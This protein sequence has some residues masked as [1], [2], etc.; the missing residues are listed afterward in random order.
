M[1]MKFYTITLFKKIKH[2]KIEK[3]I[4]FQLKEIYK[5]R[6]VRSKFLNNK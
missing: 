6:K 5:E 2:K 3:K 1:L 4:N